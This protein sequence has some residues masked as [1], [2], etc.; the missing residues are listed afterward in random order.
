MK[1][2]LFFVSLIIIFNFNICA[3]PRPLGF[4]LNKTNISQIK[5]VYQITKK[6]KNHWQGYNYYLNIVDIKLEGLNELLIICDDNN[7]VQAIIFTI[8]NEKFAEFYQLLSEKYKLI[9]NQNPYMGN[10]KIGF[11]DS[12]CTIILD[13]PHLSAN[14]S[15]I[16]ITDEFLIKFKNNQLKEYNLKNQIS[17]ELL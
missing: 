17:R 13:S 8:N 6:E 15:I 11:A 2:K 5:E 7:L 1:N 4:E 9:L 16:Y 14:M 3:N 10:K 12:D